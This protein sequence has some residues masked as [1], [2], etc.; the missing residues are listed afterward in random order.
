MTTKT[1]QMLREAASEALLTLDG[2]ADTNP[3]DR[4]DFENKDEWI[5]WAKSRAKWAA[6]KLRAPISREL[7]AER[8]LKQML[9]QDAALTQPAQAGEA[10]PYG[11]YFIED[12]E[13]WPMAG[14][15][16]RKGKERPTGTIECIAL[17]TTPPASQEQRADELLAITWPTDS[18]MPQRASQEQAQH[19]LYEDGSPGPLEQAQ[20]P[21]RY[22][23]P[24]LQ[25][26]IVSHATSEQ[27]SGG[28]VADA[29]ERIW[30]QINADGSPEDTGYPS[31]HEGVTWCWHSIGGQEVEYV[32]ADL[33]KP[34]S[35]G[36]EVVKPLFAAS[37][38]ARKWAELQADGHR[39]QSIAFDGGEGGPGTITPWGKV[40]W[41]AAPKPE[42]MMWRDIETAPKDGQCLVWV[43]T[44]DGGEVMKLSR[45]AKGEWLYEGE[46]TYSHSFYI[47]PTR[48]MPLPP[49]PSTKEPGHG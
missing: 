27:P 29:P 49:A 47:K 45:N 37:V 13:I 19:L 32:R 14:A 26:M 5:T 9:E 3:R 28:E 16:F 43:D 42:P 18:Q 2:I 35:S 46:P 20:Q 17:Y 33:A 24:A 12:P 30:L 31:D 11:H 7:L 21:S 4:A 41:G 36:G 48:W 40:M 15:G 44:D 8:V 34:Q 22:G 39:M 23:S 25:Q 38:A 10:E 1:E 6:D